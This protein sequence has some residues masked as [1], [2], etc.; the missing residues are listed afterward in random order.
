MAT[1]LRVEGLKEF[2]RSLRAADRELP[3]QL[4]TGMNH[5]AEVVVTRAKAAVPN[6]TGSLQGSIRATST[7]RE[8]RVSMGG[9]RVP[10][11][12]WMEFGGAVGRNRSIKRTKV[13]DGRYLYPSYR[14]VSGQVESRME[15]L[16][17]DLIRQV[18]M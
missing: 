4:R 12:G 7:Q 15:Q 6:R 11:A 17:G 1:H 14:A 3:R 8:G 18:G 9:A 2:Q 13:R 16:I 5:V 10:Y